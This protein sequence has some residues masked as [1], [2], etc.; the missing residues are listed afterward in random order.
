VTAIPLRCPASELYPR[1]LAILEALVGFDTT[2]DKPNLELLDYVTGLL[3]G[4]GIAVR[5]FRT[6]DGA[7]ASL[8]ATAAAPGQAGPGLVWFGHTDVVP[9]TGQSWD[10]GPFA[11]EVTADRAIGRGSADMKGFIACCLAILCAADI[12]ALPAPVT[13]ILTHDEEVGCVGA[14]RLVTQMPSWLDGAAGAIVGEPTGMTVVAGHKG[15]QNHRFRFT[16]EPRHAALA[17]QTASPVLAAAALTGHAAGLSERFR[18]GGPHDQR[19]GI[20]HSWINV[21]RIDGGV[22]P[23]IVPGECTVELEVRVIPGHSCDDIAAGLRDHAAELLAGMRELLPSAGLTAEQLSDT[24]SFVIDESHEFVKRVQAALGE[25]AAPGYVPFGTE[26]GL[27]W[28]IAGVP[29]VV[30]G[31]GHISQAHTAGE[32]VALDQLRGCLT[33]LLALPAGCHAP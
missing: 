4:N 5:L 25:R 18:T 29:A 23:N 8:A 27:I 33:A 12:D 19:F 28:G 10:T 20:G 22:K 26:A 1:M 3:A 16:G 30:C 24:P 11:L 13:L 32:W 9:V 2:S 17:P 15:K 7:K 21:G 14:R 31:P 6:D